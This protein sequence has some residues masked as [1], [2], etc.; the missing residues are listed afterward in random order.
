MR[1][2]AKAPAKR[3]MRKLM[4]DFKSDARV[5]NA[6]FEAFLIILN[7]HMGRYLEDS[8]LAA[9]HRKVIT[10]AEKDFTLAERIRGQKVITGGRTPGGRI[11][12][13]TEY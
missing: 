9:L 13:Y 7:E 12:K 5:R 1:I 6:A 2:I 8:N 10:V 11:T 4:Q 3:W